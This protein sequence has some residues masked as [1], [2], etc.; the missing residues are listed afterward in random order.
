MVFKRAS[1]FDPYVK[2]D[3]L[4]KG[5]QCESM[6]WNPVNNDLYASCGSPSQPPWKD[7]VVNPGGFWYKAT[8]PTHYGINVAK[9][10]IIDSL[11]W[12][13]G[14]DQSGGNEQKPRGI[15]FS[16]DGKTAYLVEFNN[17]ALPCVQVFKTPKVPDVT[18][19]EKV[20]N[21]VVNNYSLSNNYPNPFN[22]TTEIKFSVAKDGFVT[23]KVYDMLGK[24]VATL[25]NGQMTAG[26]Y[27]AT[28][29]AAGLNSGVYVYS[30][31]VNGVVLSHKMTLMK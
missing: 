20:D 13:L 23:L 26:N 14:P 21:N 10:T 22:P 11:S 30:L 17:S 4:A 15:A 8:I 31:S 16:K 24:E 19:V 29:N 25:A 2:T 6:G 9:K 12:V 28:F 5:F 7:P 1:E 27:T 18:G 3:T